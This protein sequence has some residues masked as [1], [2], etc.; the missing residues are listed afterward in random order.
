MKK[1]YRRAVYIG[2]TIIPLFVAYVFLK[3]SNVFVNI[4]IILRYVPRAY[5]K[6]NKQLK[7]K[8]RA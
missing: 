1:K 4:S 3:I 7:T 5:I 6:C 2:L 8:L